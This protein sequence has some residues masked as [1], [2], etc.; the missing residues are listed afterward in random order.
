MQNCIETKPGGLV[1]LDTDEHC[2][3]ATLQNK[4][5]RGTGWQFTPFW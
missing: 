3:A 2:L 5:Y 1:L 4:F